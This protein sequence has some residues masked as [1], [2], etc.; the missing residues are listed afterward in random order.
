MLS[1]DEGQSIDEL[2]EVVER[3]RWWVQTQQMLLPQ[4]FP[5][6]MG[7]VPVAATDLERNRLDC[8]ELL[9]NLKE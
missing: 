5:Q 3:A 1:R 7:P 9:G 6:R 8:E 2:D 4:V